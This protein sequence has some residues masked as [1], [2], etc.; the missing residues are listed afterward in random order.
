MQLIRTK[1]SNGKQLLFAAYSNRFIDRDKEILT[2]DSHRFNADFTDKYPQLAPDLRWFH[3]RDMIFDAKAIWWGF[4]NNYPVALFELSEA[5]SKRI[6]YLEQ[7][8]GE[9]T[10]SHGFKPFE[11]SGS[12]ITKHWTFEISLLPK[13]AAANYFTTQERTGGYMPIEQLTDE[14]QKNLLGLV[15]PE[16][17]KEFF[18]TLDT[19]AEVLDEMG[20]ESKS[21]DE[22]TTQEPA[23]FSEVEQKL[24]DVIKAVQMANDTK[25]AKLEAA[26]GVLAKELKSLNEADAVQKAAAKPAT[27]LEQILFEYKSVVGSADAELT[28]GDEL[29]TKGPKETEADSDSSSI[30]TLFGGK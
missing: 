3:N 6:D 21:T 28:D 26:M 5:D 27:P 19:T 23:D 13:S 15:T 7:E 4:D 30:Y 24:V 8:F 25:F 10:L 20:V 9:L 22:D 29:K 17:A 1:Q 12:N 11:K 18:A 14:Q 2:R 16:V